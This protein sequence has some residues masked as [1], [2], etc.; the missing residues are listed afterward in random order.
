MNEKLK[1]YILPQ[2]R[3]RLGE[4]SNLL[5]ISSKP[6]FELMIDYSAVVMEANCRIIHSIPGILRA[7]EELDALVIFGLSR[8]EGGLPVGYSGMSPW[9]HFDT[10]VRY[11]RKMNFSKP[12]M[13]HAD[14]TTAREDT[15]EGIEE[16]KEV[17]RASIGAG[18]SSA[19]VDASFWPLERNIEI[20][21]DI[22]K[23]IQDAGMG[24]ESEVGE[25]PHVGKKGEFTTVGEAVEFIEGLR[26]RGISP[27]LLAI[28]NGS[29]HGNM[30]QEE[31]R[32]IDMRRTKEIFDA[33]RK[34]CV[35]IAQHGTTGIPLKILEQFA[36]SGIR[37]ANV[38]T[39]WQNIAHRGLP[40]NLMK[41]MKHWVKNNPG[42]EIKHAT[43]PFKKEIDSI[44]EENK[45]WIEEESYKTAKMY[46]IAF[47]AQG[48]ASEFLREYRRDKKFET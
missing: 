31:I 1:Q 6:V 10:V 34:Y 13:I 11:A 15:P 22:A 32:K 3:K 27:Q 26:Q 33:I 47:R 45:K 36:D 5:L 30:T 4:N 39:E 41:R 46:F 12:F 28:N 17:I 35:S 37:K 7:A 19:N 16:A 23:I 21:A 43:Q 44:P 8:T 29:K 42:K 2:T 38:A 48:T 20:S 14:H 18:Y 40:E 24:F 9:I 25:I